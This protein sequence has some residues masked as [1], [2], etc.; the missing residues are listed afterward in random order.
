M[1]TCPRMFSFLIKEYT[2][3]FARVNHIYFT[4]L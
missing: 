2:Y 1:G 4:K 3:F